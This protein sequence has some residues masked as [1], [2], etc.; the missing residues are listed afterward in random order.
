MS[1]YDLIVIGAGPGGYVAAIRGAQL[2]KKVAIIEKNKIG[3]TCLNRGCIPT[4]ALLHAG[5]AY[6]S[7]AQLGTLG[8]G[9]ENP[10]Y[11]MEKIHARKREVVSQLTSGVE[12]LLEANKV[13]IIRGTARITGSQQVTVSTEDGEGA[14]TAED[15]LVAAGSFPARPPIPGLELPGVVTSD[16]LLE[17]EPVDYKSLVIIGGGVIGIELATFY[18]SLGCKVTIV[19]ALGRLLANMDKEF[20]Q[21]QAMLLKKRGVTVYCNSMVNSIVQ[22]GEGLTVNFTRK[23][24]EEQVTAQ[25]VLVSI[26]RR[27]DTANLFAEGLAPEMN[28]GFLVVNPDTYQTSLPHV[29]AIGD[30]IGGIQLAH[31][32]SAEGQAAVSRLYGENPAVDPRYVPSCVYTEPEIASAGITAEE[33]KEQGIPV[34]TGKYLM[35]GNGKSIIDLQ[36]RG[37]IKVVVDAES[38]KLLGIQM[39]CGRASDLVSE[40]TMAIANGMTRRDLLRGMRPHPSYCEGLTEALEAAEGESIHSM[41]AAKR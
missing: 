31:K 10:T 15:I 30:A 14:Y 1:N 5:N 23:E 8:I 27:P 11:D 22:G 16:E 38:D 25:G 28:R 13:D 40:Y 35:S 24:K 7:L 37:F 9:C 32:A 33:A 26:G 20:G 19:E 34:K 12:G 41:P 6:A 18:A 29:Y 36:E 21:S 3:G 17:G 39:M 2:G 4:K